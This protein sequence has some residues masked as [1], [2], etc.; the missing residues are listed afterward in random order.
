MNKS[1]KQKY[2]SSAFILLF[3]SVI[4]KVISAV[5]KIPLTAYIGA[6]GRGYFSI[7][8]NLCLPIHAITMGAFPL[9]LTKLVSSYDAKG[10]YLK[11]K[12]LRSVSKRLFFFVGLI[13]LAVMLIAAKPYADIIS[14]SPKSIYTIAALAP[15]VFFSCLSASH[16]AF[17]EGFL[18][19][20]PTAVS[21]IIEALF[22]MVFGLL[23]ARLAM[24]YL[25]QLYLDNASFFS[26]SVLNEQEA[27]ALIYP[28][29]SAA[30]M[31]GVTLGSICAW[32]YSSLYTKSHY[33]SFLS[34]SADK[35]AVFNELIGF[36][37]PLL[38]ATAVQ[39]ISNFLDTG[40]I[41]YC[42]TKCS[43]Q[44][45][46]QQ[47][48]YSGDEVYTYVFGVYSSALDFK[49][50]IPG[51]VMALGVAAVPAVSSAY[52]SSSERF[53]SLLTSIFKYTSILAGSGGAVLSL[54][55]KE[56]LGL[57]YSAS[58]SD[59]VSGAS[60]MLFL[61]GVT[62]M[63]CCIASTSVFCAQ[64]LGFSKQTIAPLCASA[65]LRV[66]INYFLI[67]DVRI[68]IL[69]AAVSNFFGFLV[70]TI[71]NMIII[72]KKTKARFSMTDIFIK[73]I[74]C[75][76]LTYFLTYAVRDSLFSG[77]SQW[78]SFGL[79]LSVFVITISFLMFAFKCISIG[80]LKQIK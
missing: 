23:F 26:I 62:V 16:R 25:Y 17:A 13:G 4:V 44:A 7:A 63:P 35:K 6:T 39:S 12:A 43:E 24:G 36:S 56:I 31:L 72:K 61:F 19:M 18:D 74:I 78:L 27:L 9:A 68:N 20:K 49:N 11:I 2:I 80:E 32:I 76:V 1:I 3:S 40:S 79:S 21:Q 5:Y 57:F 34:G 73:P 22:K 58:N 60:N 42:L 54:F 67:S 65:A 64:S 30:S 77:M 51:I 59:I 10:E 55:H 15:S 48:A 47:Y 38:G 8:Y 33:N 29:T 46:S 37:I 71:W 45:L 66:V 28:L 70:I 14:S 41:Q 75:C 50:L 53:S 52:E 69:G